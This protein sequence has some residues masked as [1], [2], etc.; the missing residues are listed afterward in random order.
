VLGGIRLPPSDELFWPSPPWHYH[1]AV[2]S[3]GLARDEFYPEG[4]AFATYKEKFEHYDAID[5][6][7]RMP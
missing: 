1:F 2:L 5:F 7:V 6:I 4:V 3:N